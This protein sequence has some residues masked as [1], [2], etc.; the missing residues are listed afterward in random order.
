V[1]QNELP[2]LAFGEG[3][4]AAEVRLK[5]FDSAGEYIGS[6]DANRAVRLIAANLAERRGEQLRLTIAASPRASARANGWRVHNHETPDNTR[7]TYT[8]SRMRR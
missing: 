6:I 2:P 5:T 8:F 7:E 4:R 3:G 1:R